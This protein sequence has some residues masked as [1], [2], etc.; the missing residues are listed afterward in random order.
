MSLPAPECLFTEG[1]ITLPEGYQD[2]T[3]NA[4]P[5]PVPGASAFNVS[6]DALNDA[7]TLSAYVD[8]QLALMQA[9]LKGW[10][11]TGRVPSVLGDNLL[12]GE[13]VHASYLRDGRRVFQQ[14]AVFNTEDNHILVFTMT[15]TAALTEA[16][17]AQFQRLLAS[18]RFNER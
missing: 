3:I 10:K 2:R 1:K 11:Q 18:F 8:R 4:F 5:A 13:C 15:C 12:H 16:D 6:R 7:E 17:N 14:Q 9:H